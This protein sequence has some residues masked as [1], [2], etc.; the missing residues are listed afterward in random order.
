MPEELP[1]ETIS[2]RVFDSR[3]VFVSSS[4]R[5]LWSYGYKKTWSAAV[6]VIKEGRRLVWAAPDETFDS[7]VRRQNPGFRVVNEENSPTYN[8]SI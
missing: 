2:L 6:R 1:T 8:V 7:A 3:S 5:T 4:G